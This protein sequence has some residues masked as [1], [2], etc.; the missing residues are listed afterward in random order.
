M[1]RIKISHLAII[2]NFAI[3]SP[4]V[5]CQFE[6]KTVYLNGLEE[7]MVTAQ[8][9]RKSMQDT[10]IAMSVMGSV[11]LELRSVTDIG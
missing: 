2:L 4:L 8:G 5:W 11:D 9:R 7:I 1:Y 3:V 6:G 10:P